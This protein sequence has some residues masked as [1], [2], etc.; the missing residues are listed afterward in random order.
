MLSHYQKVTSESFYKEG[1]RNKKR[2]CDGEMIRI[3]FMPFR[4]QPQYRRVCMKGSVFQ[5]LKHCSQCPCLHPPLRAGSVI[6]TWAVGWSWLVL[7]HPIIVT[8]GAA[9]SW[10]QPWCH[11]S[12]CH[13][14]CHHRHHHPHLPIQVWHCSRRTG[15]SGNR[16]LP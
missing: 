3:I 1:S 7:N 13:L 2:R 12:W 8:I 9:Q 16:S 15:N 14:W 10:C 6:F 11:Q 4:W 5:N